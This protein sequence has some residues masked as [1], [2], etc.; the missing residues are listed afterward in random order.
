[1]GEYDDFV[2][3]VL[4]NKMALDKDS[5]K[6]YVITTWL[7]QSQESAHPPIRTSAM[8]SQLYDNRKNP[9]TCYTAIV[10][11]PVPKK[12]AI[13]DKN[14]HLLWIHLE[15]D[16]A[17]TGYAALDKVNYKSLKADFPSKKFTRKAP[18]PIEGGIGYIPLG[19]VFRRSPSGCI[20]YDMKLT[21]GD[22]PVEKA[23]AFISRRRHIDDINPDTILE[24]RA[25]SWMAET[26][27]GNVYLR[28]F[29][30]KYI[31][32]FMSPFVYDSQRNTF[33]RCRT[34]GGPSTASLIFA[35]APFTIGRTLRDTYIMEDE[36]PLTA[37]EKAVDIPSIL[38]AYLECSALKRGKNIL[39][40]VTWYKYVRVRRQVHDILT[41]VQE[42]NQIIT[43]AATDA[44]TAI[45]YTADASE[46]YIE[47]KGNVRV[48]T[49]S[50]DALLSGLLGD[51]CEGLACFI[52]GVVNMFRYLD[53]EDLCKNNPLM[54]ELFQAVRFVRSF[55]ACFMVVGS[56]SSAYI[57]RE[58][59]AYPTIGSEEDMR[60]LGGHGWAMDAP[61][62]RL[63]TMLEDCMDKRKEPS[64]DSAEFRETIFKYI[65]QTYQS[66][67]LAIADNL[68]IWRPGFPMKVD[69][70]QKMGM[71]VLEGTGPVISDL[72]M[73]AFPKH[74]YDFMS[75]EKSPSQE[76][77]V[78][79]RLPRL[80]HLPDERW[81]DFY[82]TMVDIMG[83]D[84]HTF[85]GGYSARAVTYQGG[86]P[87]LGAHMEHFM[88]SRSAGFFVNRVYISGLE[89]D[90][91]YQSYVK[92]IIAN[93]PRQ[94]L[95]EYVHMEK[96][97]PIKAHSDFSSI[98]EFV[99]LYRDMAEKCLTLSEGNFL[100]M[101]CEV[102][103]QSY[104]NARPL[105]IGETTFS[106]TK[107]PSLFFLDREVSRNQGR[108]RYAERLAENLEQE[109]KGHLERIHGGKYHGK[110]KVT[111]IKVMVIRHN[112][113]SESRIE[114][115]YCTTGVVPLPQPV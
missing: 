76:L 58:G 87:F 51:D 40:L 103:G 37:R 4:D 41:E 7:T 85:F 72:E 64:S 11:M 88:S 67:K 61:I 5:K 35:M 63:L 43:S 52:V 114:I 66:A 83:R 13:D 111:R 108:S 18:Y 107:R 84:I 3:V 48:S 12:A 45:R 74:Q 96:Y 57:S 42:W 65:S 24:I 25:R 17:T 16:Q 109:M 97:K 54:L 30:D 92:Y 22:I 95:A 56:V 82:K 75:K 47:G 15:E 62:A 100:Q 69:A 81:T 8:K 10:T 27:S 6:Q 90:P 21:G 98:K 23:C 36:S 33:T 105:D 31:T 104:N 78:A 44:A 77:D 110:P 80:S 2:V 49:E 19:D 29:L 102:L 32:H 20:L 89:N 1:M 60:H 91:V 86:S 9:V 26:E 93:R 101:F 99:S 14:E 70:E 28:K 115:M 73:M 68:D 34:V 53:W 55:F 112:Q 38:H 39:D 94:G 79:P 71:T 50:W 46:I 106:V 59:G 113:T